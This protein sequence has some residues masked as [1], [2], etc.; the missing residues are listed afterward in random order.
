MYVLEKAEGEAHQ[1]SFI[2]SVKFRDV[3]C[4]GTTVSQCDVIPCDHCCPC[5][6]VDLRDSKMDAC[7]LLQVRVPAKR[8]RNNTQPKLL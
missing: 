7:F 6:F 8:W 3:S 2:F 1:P 5:E 4:T